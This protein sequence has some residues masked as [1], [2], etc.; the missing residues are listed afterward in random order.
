MNRAERR[1]MMK[2]MPG[3]KKALKSATEKAVDDLEMMFRRNWEEEDD[4][5]L[6]NGEG[7]YDNDDGE[8]DIYND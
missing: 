6:N 7:S 8:D 2:T 1:K 3:Y 4:E 5:T